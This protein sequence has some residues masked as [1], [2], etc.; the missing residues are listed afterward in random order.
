[1]KIKTI[2]RT[3]EDY[4]RKSKLDIVKVHRN[5]DPALHPF[6][7]ARE[8]QKAVVATKLDKIF[9]KPFIGA[10]DGHSDGV[11]CSSSVRNKNVP[12]I[13]G[14]CD[15]ELKV[16]DLSRRVCF[17]SAVAHQGFVRGVSPDPTGATFFSCGDDKVVKQ[18]ALEPLD[19]DAVKPLST[20]VATHPLTGVD[21]HW[22]DQQVRTH[23]HTRTHERRFTTYT[24]HPPTA[25]H[26][27]RPP[28]RVGLEPP[29]ARALVQVGHGHDALGQV[30]PGGKVSAG[31]HVR[32]PRR[33]SVRPAHVRAHAQVRAV[34]EVQQG[35]LLRTSK[36][37]LRV[38]HPGSPIQD[39][40]PFI[41]RPRPRPRPPG[42]LEPH[43]AVQFRAGQRGKL[44]TPHAACAASQ[45]LTRRPPAHPCILRAD[46]KDHNLYSFD[47]RKL[48][49][50]LMIHKDHVSAVMDVAF[51][52]TGRE[53]VSGSYDRTLRIFETADGRSREVY[54]T[55]RMQRIFCVNY[56]ADARFVLS[57]SDDTNVRI[58]KAEASDNLG[59]V[60]GRQERKERFNDTVKKRFAHMPE[61]KRVQKDKKVP[62]SIKKAVAIKHIQ[63]T[64]ERRK[65]DNRKR[66]SRPEDVEMQPE[67]KRAVLKEFK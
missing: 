48:E 4:T 19:T 25:G 10:L 17:W 27:R 30:Q 2:S 61:V 65:Q 13:T 32:G 21:H 26:V 36:C 53:F 33:E 39:T 41:P 49:K 57:G 12:F 59:V 38:D 54:H 22:V 64:S 34:D 35:A 31:V 28:R 43:G 55:K 63:T 58:W 44:S 67:K 29:R 45:R 37:M 16:W 15:G 24:V 9:A 46:Q 11:F 47:M 6:E 40:S 18:W 23:V 50:A 14:A 20:H 7:R 8:Y 60:P 51:S 56:S 52:P 66:H 5:R 3:E 1:M 62:K 42:V